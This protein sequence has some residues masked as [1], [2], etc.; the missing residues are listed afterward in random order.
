LTLPPGPFGN[1]S[2][3]GKSDGGCVDVAPLLEFFDF[4]AIG[5]ILLDVIGGV[6]VQDQVG[7][8]QKLND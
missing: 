8:T 7:I 5:Q 1:L 4:S 3:R 2:F 6:L